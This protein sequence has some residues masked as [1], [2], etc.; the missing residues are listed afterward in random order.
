M[1][2]DDKLNEL[3]AII[4]VNPFESICHRPLISLE[5]TGDQR[6]DSSPRTNFVS[7]SYPAETYHEGGLV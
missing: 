7:I 4:P 2:V 5:P 1:V 6:V 3:S